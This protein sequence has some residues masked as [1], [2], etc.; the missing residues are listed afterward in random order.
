MKDVARAAETSPATVSKVLNGRADEEAISEACRERVMAACRELGYVRQ[1]AARSLRTGRSYALG[2]LLAMNGGCRDDGSLERMQFHAPLLAGMLGA[3]NEQG[4]ELIAVAEREGRSPLENG[5]HLL[6]TGRIEGLIVPGIYARRPE[7][8]RAMEESDQPIILALW[9]C[10]TR[11]PQVLVDDLSAIPEVLDHFLEL[12]HC[13][14]AWMGPAAEDDVYSGRRERVYRRWMKDN[15]R[16]PTVLNPEPSVGPLTGP[17]GERVRTLTGPVYELIRREPRPTALLC[18]NEAWAVAAYHAAERLGLSVPDNLSV[19][20]FDNIYGATALPPLSVISLDL[21]RVG[22]R[23]VHI[24]AD[25]AAGNIDYAD[26]T[27]LI[28]QVATSYVRRES[29]VHAPE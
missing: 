4:L 19:V 24:L 25:V 15:D 13:R 10:D 1:H 26:L 6:D 12:G 17:F 21:D 7:V 2:G 28:E 18:Y 23:A 16:E 3:A 9:K 11:L 29:V 27:G 8:V 20:G 14:I 22:A 5:L